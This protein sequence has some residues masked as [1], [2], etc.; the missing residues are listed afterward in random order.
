MKLSRRTEKELREI[1]EI[2]A[3]VTKNCFGFLL[4]VLILG[5]MFL[6]MGW[7]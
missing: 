4:F 2:I 6:V 7:K 3:P 5:E 1:M